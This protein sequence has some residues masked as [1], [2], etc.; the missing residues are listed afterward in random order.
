MPDRPPVDDSEL[1]RP[2]PRRV[3]PAARPR[4]RERLPPLLRKVKTAR[5][6]RTLIVRFTLVRRAR[7]A[8]IA[9]RKGKVGRAHQ[10]AADAPRAPLADA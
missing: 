8:L 4:R 6:G 10:A 1:F 9:R 2:P 5:R 7:V 3:E